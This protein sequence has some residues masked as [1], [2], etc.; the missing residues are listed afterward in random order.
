M[1]GFVSKASAFTALQTLRGVQAAGDQVRLEVSTGLKVRSAS[2]NPAFFVV[3]Q[4]TRGDAAILSGLRDNLSFVKG[5]VGAGEAAF[6]QLDTLLLQMYDLVPTAQTG[7]AIE[8]QDAVFYDLLDQFRDTIDAASFQ[9]TNLLT[10]SD[11]TSV[12]IGLDRTGQSFNFQTLQVEGGDF[13]RDSFFDGLE[14]SDGEFVINAENFS[15]R[16]S[17]V[18]RADGLVN[19]WVLGTGAF[20]GMM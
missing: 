13:L 3:S 4:K 5:A 11:A 1:V 8:S 7:V 15:S 6:R 18:G 10:Q 17:A 16:E 20:A 12:T 9:G 19:E 14:E 2:N